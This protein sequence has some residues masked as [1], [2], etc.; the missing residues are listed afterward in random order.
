MP[1]VPVSPV[2]AINLSLRLVRSGRFMR[3]SRLHVAIVIV[4]YA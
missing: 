3:V 4:I 2:L 1:A